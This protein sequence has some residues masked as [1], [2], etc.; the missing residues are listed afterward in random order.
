MKVICSRKQLDMLKESIK[1]RY[2]GLD[3]GT[4]LIVSNAITCAIDQLISTNEIDD[5]GYIEALLIC[6]Q[7]KEWVRLNHPEVQCKTDVL[8][9]DLKTYIEPLDESYYG[10]DDSYSWI[11]SLFG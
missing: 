1:T 7:A 10:I 5:V 9:D 6:K 4:I 8:F 11:V 2:P 3:E